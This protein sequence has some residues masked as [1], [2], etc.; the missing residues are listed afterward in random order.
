LLLYP[1]GIAGIGLMAGP[2]WPVG[3]Q[4]VARGLVSGLGLVRSASFVF[5][6]ITRGHRC[7]GAIVT[8]FYPAFD[9]PCGHRGRG[10]RRAR[11][12]RERTWLL[13]GAGSSSFAP[14]DSAYLLQLAGNTYHPAA[15]LTRR[16]WSPALWWRRRR[17]SATDTQPSPAPRAVLLVAGLLHAGRHHRAGDRRLDA[18]RAARHRCSRSAH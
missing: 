8:T 15:W 9:L 16:I 13:L 1:L 6:R 11:A 3:G 2:G 5:P 12:W 18:P 4:H 7:T 14:T 17:R 10:D